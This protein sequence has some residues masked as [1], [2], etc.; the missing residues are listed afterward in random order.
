MKEI[1][2]ANLQVKGIDDTVYSQLKALAH[3]ENRSVSQQVILLLKRHLATK[4]EGE[5]AGLSAKVLL[6]L[7]GSWHDRR[8]AA[9]IVKELKAA[10]K[11]SQEL[12]K[13]W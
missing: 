5:K 3:S 13:G 6:D 1:K 9:A 8:S 12:T 10:R 2:M 4:R 7:A 11:K